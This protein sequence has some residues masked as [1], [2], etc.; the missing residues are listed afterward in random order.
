MI[1]C[2]EKR[3][4]KIDKFFK[5]HISYDNYNMSQKKIKNLNDLNSKFL[6]R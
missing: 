6:N 4:L 3:L 1:I 2:S 5:L